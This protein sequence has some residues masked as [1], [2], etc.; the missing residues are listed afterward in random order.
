MDELHSD[1]PQLEI[2]DEVWLAITPGWESEDVLFFCE[3]LPELGGRR[4]MMS[5]TSTSIPE[6][7]V[8]GASA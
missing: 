6:I 5:G 1:F 3:L 8:L 7:K 4:L 2:I